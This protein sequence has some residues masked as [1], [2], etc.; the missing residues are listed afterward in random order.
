MSAKVLYVVGVAMRIGGRIWSAPAPKRHPD[1]L[2]AL[3]D[4][5]VCNRVPP[6]DQGFLLSNGTFANRSEAFLIASAAEQI[7][8]RQ[9]GQYDGDELFSEDVW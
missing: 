8:P 4:F 1:L 9:P 7:I 2:I 6:A 3:E 5:G